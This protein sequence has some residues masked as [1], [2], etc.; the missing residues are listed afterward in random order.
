[1]TREPL[2]LLTQ[3]SYRRSRLVTLEKLGLVQEAGDS[4]FYFRPSMSL[5]HFPSSG[6]PEEDDR[7]RNYM[8]KK[9]RAAD[10]NRERR[11]ARL[12]KLARMDFRM[13]GGV[14]PVGFFGGSGGG[15]G[16]FRP[17]TSSPRM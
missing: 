9:Q 11:L 3:E 4:G 5:D 16:T 1:M 2:R 15:E 17:S 14:A 12:R 6:D 10:Q 13:V 7:L 8:L